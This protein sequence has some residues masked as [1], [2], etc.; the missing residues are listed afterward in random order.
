[1]EPLWK[2]AASIERPSSPPPLLP[3][4]LAAGVASSAAGDE[5]PALRVASPVAGAVAP[6]KRLASPVKSVPP[7]TVLDAPHLKWGGPFFA[8][9]PPFTSKA[10]VFGKN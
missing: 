5:T 9:N 3:A 1:M 8:E 2:M 7:Q 6:V 4:K 10:A